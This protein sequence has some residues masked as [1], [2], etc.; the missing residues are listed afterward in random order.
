MEELRE[1]L[2]DKY[3]PKSDYWLRQQMAWEHDRGRLHYLAFVREVMSSRG[4]GEAL[5][6]DCG[7]GWTGLA[8]AS[9]GFKPS[10]AGSKG[11]CFDFLKWRLK[12]QGLD[13]PAYDLIDAPRLPLAVSFDSLLKY[14]DVWA[15]IQ[16]LATSGDIVIFN[17]NERWPIIKGSTY[18][19][20]VASLKKQILQS[21]TV[22]SY[23][24]YNHYAH[25]FAIVGTEREEK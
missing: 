16:D 21:L 25:L 24:T 10:F 1:F 3:S 12:R 2:G 9:N 14:K 8:L 17:L 22:L 7:T 5:D 18:R 6:W 19:V 15:A 11:K 4:A 13:Y 20:G 23:K